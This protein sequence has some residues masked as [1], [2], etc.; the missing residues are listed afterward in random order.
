[1]SDFFWLDHILFVLLG[2]AFPVSALRS[3]QPQLANIRQWTS[4]MKR[5]LYISNSSMLLGLAALVL[6]VWY[7]SG[8]PFALLGFRLSE[9][10]SLP[11]GLGLSALFMLAYLLD[12]YFET[13]NEEALQ[14]TKAHWQ[15]NTPFLPENRREMQ[16]F[17]FLIFGA[18]VGEEI[19]FRG[20]ML[21]YMLMWFGMSIPAQGLAIVLSSG[22]FAVIHLYQG[23]KAVFKI[24][25]LSVIFGVI[26]L[27][28]KSL[29]LP[30][31]LHFVIDLLGGYFSV[32]LSKKGRNVEEEKEEKEVEKVKDGEEVKEG[33]EEE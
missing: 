15:K 1:M 2:I 27:H 6:I 25:V 3:A 18:A 4:D 30:I 12:I 26:F 22:I 23:W 20:F 19:V 11:L 14:K 21:T 32:W 10:G 7:F 5:V 8:R 29:L 33:E 24:A 28:T 31:V 16:P 17:Y 13:R 9:A